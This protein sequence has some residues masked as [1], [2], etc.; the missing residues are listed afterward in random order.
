M[1]GKAEIAGKSKAIIGKLQFADKGTVYFDEISRLPAYV[2]QRLIEV[3]RDRR[4]TQMGSYAASSLDIRIICSNNFD[5]EDC[6]EK[7]EFSNVLYDKLNVSHI[8]LPSLRAR[9][10]DVVVLSEHLLKQNAAAENRFPPVL[11]KDAIQLLEQQPWSGNVRQLYN[12]L[13]RVVLLSQL[14]QVDAATI[15]LVQQLEPVNYTLAKSWHTNAHAYFDV[16]GQIKKLRSIENEVIQLA[17]E[18]SGG[19][20]TRAAKNLGIGRST[21]YRK[22]DEMLYSA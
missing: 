19:C 11:T 8:V 20:M 14:D 2:Q 17:I 1:F 6:V 21:L 15:R 18:S 12:L 16:K 5:I 22:M 4:V 7:G 3:L 9:R 10:D 13:S